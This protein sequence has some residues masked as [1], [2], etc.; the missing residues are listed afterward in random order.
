MKLKC[1]KAWL[2]TNECFNG[3]ELKGSID[4][5]KNEQNEVGCE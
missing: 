3:F 2:E 1:T 4:E 5:V